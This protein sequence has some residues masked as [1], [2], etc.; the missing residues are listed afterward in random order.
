MASSP[1]RP[2]SPAGEGGTDNNTP[3]NCLGPD[4]I[5][6]MCDTI[7]AVLSEDASR[8]LVSKALVEL[9]CF[10]DIFIWFPM[11]HLL[12]FCQ[13]LGRTRYV[14]TKTAIARRGEV[15]KAW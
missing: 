4:S 8:E 1:A 14:S 12:Y 2:S 10:I 9:D 3:E 7:S 5:R 15:Y 6:T 11:C 13:H